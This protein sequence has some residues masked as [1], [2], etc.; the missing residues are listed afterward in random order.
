MFRLQVRSLFVVLSV[1]S[2]I[3]LDYLD[4]QSVEALK[5]PCDERGSSQVLTFAQQVTWPSGLNDTLKNRHKCQ[6]NRVLH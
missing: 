5:A 2:K 3:F 4:R 1:L 6:T